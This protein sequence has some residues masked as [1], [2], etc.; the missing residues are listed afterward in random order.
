MFLFYQKEDLC[1]VRDAGYE[2]TERLFAER[3]AR[4]QQ[5]RVPVSV[6]A[7]H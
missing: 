5:S 4:E 2:G 1:V 3:R 6:N 7:L